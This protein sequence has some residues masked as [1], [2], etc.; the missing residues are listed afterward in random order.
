MRSLL[1][2][3]GLGLTSLDYRDHP[4]HLDHID[5][6]DHLD[7]DYLFDHLYHV[8]CFNFLIIFVISI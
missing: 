7:P 1:P 3:D 6:V 8:E 2:G 5:C 4:V